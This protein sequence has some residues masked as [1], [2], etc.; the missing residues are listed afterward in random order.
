MGPDGKEHSERTV[1]RR[2][3]H[4]PVRDNGQECVL[5]RCF[6]RRCRVRV[7]DSHHIW[8]GILKYQ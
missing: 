8:V 1:G 3:K 6:F 2:S 7:G 4:A 5:R